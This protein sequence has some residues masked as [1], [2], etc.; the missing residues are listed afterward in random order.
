MEDCSNGK[1][2]LSIEMLLLII[3]AFGENDLAKLKERIEAC[4]KL[5]FEILSKANC[6]KIKFEFLTRS[7][8]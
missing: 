8:A 2:L 7:F 4:K 3:Y 6:Q 5:K 1:K